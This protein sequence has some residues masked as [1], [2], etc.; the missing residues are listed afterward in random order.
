MLSS[1]DSARMKTKWEPSLLCPRLTFLLA[2]CFS[3][4]CTSQSHRFL[5]SLTMKPVTFL[6]GN[7]QGGV[8]MERLIQRDKCPGE[9]TPTQPIRG[10]LLLPALPG[11]CLLH[12]DAERETTS[13]LHLPPA[14]TGER[15]SQQ[16]ETRCSVTTD[17]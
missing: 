8:R 2:F 15:G 13:L 11:I 6:G 5:Q 16:K 9:N 4:I 12:Q 17:D 7:C 3:A 10:I 14:S 1:K